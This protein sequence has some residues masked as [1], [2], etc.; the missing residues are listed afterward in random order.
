MMGQTTD[1]VEEAHGSEE[2]ECKICY[3]PY[4]LG[5]RR[6]KLLKCHHRLCAKCLAKLL[7]LGDW[8]PCA[9]VC[10]FC[11]YV[12]NLPDDAS[13]G[14]PD[15]GGL[16][17]ALCS[18]NYLMDRSTNLLLSPQRLGSL[19]DSFL[20]SSSSNCLFVTIMETAQDPVGSQL[21]CNPTTPAEWVNRSS[22]LDSMVQRWTVWTCTTSLCQ[23]LAQAL[24]WLLG[25]VYLS[26]LPLGVYLLIMQKTPM[27]MFLVSLVPATLVAI[28]VY[29]FCRCICHELRDCMS[30]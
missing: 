28:M 18:Q 9:V 29:A 26:S 24:V 12:T 20:S 13:G 30:S 3:C 16:V 4:S 14:I 8:P 11:R 27:G 6:P 21:D 19:A 23:L 7:D 5:C 1:D 15:D 22:S 2:L 17:E 25:F 10:P